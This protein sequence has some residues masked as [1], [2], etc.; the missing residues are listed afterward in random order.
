MT[1][2]APGLNDKVA[3]LL[4]KTDIIAKEQHELQGLVEPYTSTSGV[5]RSLLL[6]LQEQLQAQA[7]QGWDLPFVPQAYKRPGVENGIENENS[8]VKHSIPTITLPMPANPGSKLLFPEAYLS[9][10]AD[11][12]TEVG[13]R[14]LRET[15]SL[16]NL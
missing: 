11:Q 2:N 14:P 15:F 3:G 13:P 8:S 5:H 4:E 16:T 9:I 6:L 10:Y 1:S 7:E 12:E